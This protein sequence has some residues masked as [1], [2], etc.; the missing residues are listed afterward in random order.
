MYNTEIVCNQLTKK[1]KKKS[2]CFQ[3]LGQSRGS[4]SGGRTTCLKFESDLRDLRRVEEGRF[5]W[6]VVIDGRFI[7]HPVV[8]NAQRRR[9]KN[10]AFPKSFGIQRM[11]PA[12]SAAVLSDILRHT[13]IRV[14]CVNA[15]KILYCSVFNNTQHY[16]LQITC[17][18]YYFLPR[19]IRFGGRS[20]ILETAKNEFQSM[21][22]PV[23]GGADCGLYR[24]RM[25]VINAI[26]WSVQKQSKAAAVL[27][28]PSEKWQ[29]ICLSLTATG[30]CN[31]LLL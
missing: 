14:P 26:N 7:G 6:R 1:E 28:V 25:I 19:K 20:V 5:E 17:L 31:A 10:V 4:N 11:C 24:L 30:Y 2:L 23:E 8:G 13:G 21:I 16:C 15:T 3:W 18:L 12:W 29:E 27:K 9:R 22:H